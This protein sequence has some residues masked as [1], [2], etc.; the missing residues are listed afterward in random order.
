MENIFRD[1]VKGLE[2]YRWITIQDC[3]EEMGISVRTLYKYL[4]EG[5]IKGVLYKKTRLVDS[6]S[7]IEY[8]YKKGLIDLNQ[9]EN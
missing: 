8:L 2:K 5:K 3:S 6:L 4:K 7:C 1:K 9:I